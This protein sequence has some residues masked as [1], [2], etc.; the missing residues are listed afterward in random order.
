LN[1]PSASNSKA[2]RKII[3]WYDAN[4]RVLPW[5][6]APNNSQPH[7]LPDPYFVW[8]SEIMLQQTQVVTV[9][10][11]FRKFISEWPTIKDLARAELEEVLKAWAGLG[12]YSRARNLK[13]CAQIVCEEYQGQ[14]PDDIALLKKLP[15]IGE[16][17][18]A[19]LSAIAFGRPVAV[20]DGNVE[21][22]MTRIHAISTP[23]SDSKRQIR[24][25]T[26]RLVPVERPGD[27]AQ[28]VM[29]LGATICTPKNPSCDRCPWQMICQA[30]LQFDP[31]NFPVKIA[32][33]IIPKRNGAAFVAITQRGE[34]LLRKRADKG[35]LAG[36]SEV[37]STG[38][39]SRQDGETGIEAAPFSGK[40]LTAGQVTHQFTHFH[41]AM[42]V[43]YCLLNDRAKVDGWWVTAE[44][45]M[46]EALPNLMKTALTLALEKIKDSK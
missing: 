4:A 38:W 43:Y 26:S 25:L 6:V 28:A 37:P 7:F 2:T 10:A 3:D 40:W 24:E 22:V 33:K 15:G 18:S 9:Q 34:I 1:T 13:K 31:V 44:N 41:L 16:Y 5:R 20:V 39:S 27:F 23:V 46:D 30:H 35:M 14:F 36:M 42:K 11:Y 32:K 29:D 19:A 21:R 17:T 8:L 45:V 12:Y